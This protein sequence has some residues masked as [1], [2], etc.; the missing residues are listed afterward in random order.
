MATDRA[1]NELIDHARFDR[2][3]AAATENLT[4][5]KAWARKE[6]PHFDSYLTARELQLSGDFDEASQIFST[7]ISDE[8]AGPE[9][10]LH[11][12]ECELAHSRPQQALDS[13]RAN[14][15]RDEVASPQVWN[16]WLQIAFRDLG[17]TPQQVQM[18]LPTPQMR[19]SS[20]P[21]CEQHV[22]WLLD[23]L[24]NSKPVRLNCGGE[25]YIAANGD[26]WGRDAFFTYGLEYFGTLGDAAVFS[27][28]IRNTADGVLYQTERFFSHERTDI[29][30]AYRIPL[31]NGTY[32]VT[33][34]FAEIYDAHRSFDV[35]VE[36]EVVWS[37]H[38]PSVSDSDWATAHQ[39]HLQVVIEDGQFD[40][41]FVSRENTDPK[42]SCLQISA[43]S[44]IAPP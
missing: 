7:L 42:I 21:R 15:A 8:F 36:N 39:H 35:R 19:L 32:A 30:P 16:L 40:L 29:V 38:D 26:E 1:A 31:P 4:N 37:E 28:P 20:E 25:Q 43:V 41:Y 24:I 18:D 13:L 22:R 23:Q 10:L 9:T 33:L 12:A 5:A 44:G 6:S 11:Y 34:G 27:Q 3:D 2:D 14:L 17:P